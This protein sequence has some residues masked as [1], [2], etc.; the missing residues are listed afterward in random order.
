[1]PPLSAHGDF[2][3]ST[4]YKKHGRKLPAYGREKNT[5]FRGTGGKI[6]PR[7]FFTEPRIFPPVTERI[8]KSYG[9]CGDAMRARKG[10]SLKGGL[11][12]STRVILTPFDGLNRIGC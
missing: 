4:H 11:E 8:I 10:K 9:K 6:R 3:Y 1:M 5:G 2:L 7:I 12:A